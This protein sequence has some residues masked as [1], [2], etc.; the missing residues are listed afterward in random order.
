MFLTQGKGQYVCAHCFFHSSL[1]Q[2]KP[3]N[4]KY[5]FTELSEQPNNINFC[6]KEGVRASLVV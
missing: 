4:P 3:R 1:L 2:V 6:Y 5:Y